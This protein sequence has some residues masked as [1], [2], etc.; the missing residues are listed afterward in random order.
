MHEEIMTY[1]WDWGEPR[2]EG[3]EVSLVAFFKMK[4]G[5]RYST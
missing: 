3:E 4:C 1:V 5:K 2:A